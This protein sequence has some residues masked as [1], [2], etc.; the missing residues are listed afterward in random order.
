MVF[1]AIT[2][3]GLKEALRLA[4]ADN[5][6]AWCGADAISEADYLGQQDGNLSRF[7]YPL[8]GESREVIEGAIESVKEHHPNETVWVESGGE[9]WRGDRLDVHWDGSAVCVTAVGAYGDPLDLGE[10]EV[11]AFIKKLQDC[12]RQA[13]GEKAEE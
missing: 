10:E 13:R 1:L 4:Q 7:D 11:E 6:A 8:A 2:S 9:R 12:L 5:S 3:T